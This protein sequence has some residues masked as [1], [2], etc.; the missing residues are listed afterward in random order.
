ML[1]V[2]VFLAFS[3]P[4]LMRK[5]SWNMKFVFLILT[6]FIAVTIIAGCTDFSLSNPPTDKT[7]PQK[8]HQPETSF[9]ESSMT[10]KKSYYRR[11]G[12]THKKF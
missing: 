12:D 11:F 3:V 8:E 2:I 7:T 5:T 9:A 4:C 6:I 1:M 10:D